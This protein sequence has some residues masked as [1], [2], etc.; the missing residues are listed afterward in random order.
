MK[1]F[2]YCLL[3]SASLTAAPFAFAQSPEA[4]LIAVLKSDA[5][6]QQKADACIDLGR[7]GTKE[8]VATLA[9]LLGDE[10][11]AHMARYGLEPIPDP[12][13]DAAVLAALGQLKGRTLVGVVQSIGVRRD[14]H[15]VGPLSK[16]L[17]DP[18]GEVA[19]AAATSLGKI[20]T[21]PAEAA[22]KQALGKVPAAAEGL[23]RCAETAQKPSQAAALYDAVRAAQ[24]PPSVKAAATRGAILARGKAGTPL[25]IEQLKGED[26]VLFAAALRV[27][28]EL[29]GKEVTQALA[30]ELAKL[31]AERQGRVAAVLAERG[32]AAAVP[33][34]LALARG[35]TPEVRVS[36]I[37]ALTRL[38]AAAA[39]PVLAELASYKD[40]EV[41][42]AA[43]FALAGFSGPNVNATIIELVKN[44]D[45]KVRLIG[46]ELIGRRRI[47]AAVPELLRLAAEPDPQIS[48]AALKV[49]GD[50][51]G[52]KELPALLGILQKAPT[53]EAAAEALSAV[54]LR[55]SVCAPGSL[56]VRKAVY[57]VLPAGTSADV[58]A[59]VAELVKSGQSVIEVSNNTFGD[60]APNQPKKFRVDYTVNGLAKSA[61]A[62]EGSTLRL[63]LGAG[64]TP[65]EV[66]GPLHAAYA[67]AQGA[68]KLALLRLLCSF[69]G[70]QALDVVRAA[71]GDANAEVKEAAQRA[72]CDWPTAEALPDLAKMVQA[73]PSPKLKILALRGYIR[74]AAAQEIAA[75]EKAAAL[76]QALGWSERDEERRLVLASLGGAPSPEALALA[77]TCLDNASLKEDAGLAAVTLAE[78]LVKTHPAEVS[79]VMKKVVEVGGNEALLKRARECLGQIK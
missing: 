6:Q 10:K 50:L 30:A 76:K 47:G 75:A 58:T 3:I 44:P 68:P 62:N 17:A 33:A 73:P 59:K 63:E 54:C 37:G 52:V 7:V 70:T 5:P 23:L 9:A 27:G 40:A 65:A 12:A 25:L 24:V 55:Q 45:V 28:I 51:G 43:Q 48:G 72:L 78:S 69:G 41:A 21:A 35:G 46:V 14:A 31:P 29:P 66:S 42:K 39:V 18:D 57:G 53:T 79:G 26:A 22:L 13:V 64:A 71:A 4:A 77:A 56:V 32:D 60:A 8:A 74:L 16:L 2:L 38:G 15:A 49:L 11:L 61:T 36:A 67:Q 19:A 1:N 20:G 34:L